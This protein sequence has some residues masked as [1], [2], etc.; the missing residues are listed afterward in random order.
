MMMIMDCLNVDGTGSVDK[1]H[2]DD[3]YDY[4]ER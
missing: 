2:D 4:D 1:I 3:H